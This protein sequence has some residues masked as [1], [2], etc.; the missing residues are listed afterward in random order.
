[1][2]QKT[3]IMHCN[4]YKEALA[5]DPNFKGESGHVHS[6]ANCQAYSSDILATIGACVI[7]YSGV[8]SDDP[9]LTGES[10]SDQ[11]LAQLNHEPWAL[12]P[13]SDAIEDGALAPHLAIQ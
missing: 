1:M 6:C 12:L 13:T 2:S 3:D 4:D 10:L 8:R 7:R 5:A 11:V 9:E